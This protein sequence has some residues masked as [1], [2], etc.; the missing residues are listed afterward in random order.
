MSQLTR[1]PP[2]GPPRGRPPS[3]GD[4]LLVLGAGAVIL[5][6]TAG[7]ASVSMDPLL[8]LFEASSDPTR[9]VVI[10]FF[11][12]PYLS[13]LG[14][15]YLLVLRRRG[16]TW[17]DLGL[18]PAAPEWLGRTLWVTLLAFSL[19]IVINLLIQSLSGAPA[20]NP[21][22]EALAPRGSSLP[23]FLV[24]LAMV[25]GVVPFVEELLFRGLLYTLLRRHL[26]ISPSVVISALLFAAL[27]MIPSLMPSLFVIGVI[28]ALLYERSRS[29]WPAIGMHGLHNALMLGLLELAT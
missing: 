10:L 5:L 8:K 20:E 22:V 1:L 29:L 23:A 12:V 19:V 21:Q 24:L 13:L 14:A 16:L 11:A 6:V 28:L 9:L 4:V 26:G 27:H 3:G 25:A 15:I 7:L 2:S 18:R 17:G